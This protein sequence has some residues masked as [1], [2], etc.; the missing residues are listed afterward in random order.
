MLRISTVLVVLKTR[1]TGSSDMPSVCGIVETALYSRDVEVA[2]AFYRR[3]F[4]FEVLLNSPRLVALMSPNESVLLIFQSGATKEPYTT[5]G[6]VIPGHGDGGAGHFAF[7]IEA[8]EV[9]SWRE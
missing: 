7:G 8:D 6:G 5:V 1:L 3:V 9:A 2:V 4:G